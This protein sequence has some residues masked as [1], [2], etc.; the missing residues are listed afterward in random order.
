MNVSN[1]TVELLSLL[2]GLIVAF[3]Q[4][5]GGCGFFEWCDNAS[6]ATYMP[7]MSF[8]SR[9]SSQ[10]PDLLCPC[11]AGSCLILTAKTGKNVGQ[12]FYRCPANQ[13]SLRGLILIDFQYSP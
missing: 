9:S 10:F 3:V 12:Q 5:N 8:D 6:G 11:G 7:N 13:V 1:L 2:R 4:E